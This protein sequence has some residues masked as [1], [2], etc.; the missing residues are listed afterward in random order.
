LK[1][2][3]RWTALASSA[4]MIAVP[5]G[6][7]T[8]AATS[9]AHASAPSAGPAEQTSCPDPGVLA[10][11]H[12]TQ[13]GLLQKAIADALPCAFTSTAWEPAGS[14]NL[15]VYLTPLNA[16]T[17]GVAQAIIDK[18]PIPNVTMSL[19]Q[20][21]QSYVRGKEQADAVVKQFAG[22]VTANVGADGRVELE[23][24][25]VPDASL[26]AASHVANYQAEPTIV[27]KSADVHVTAGGKQQDWSPGSAYTGS[28]LDLIGAY[29][30]GSCDQW[31]NPSTST[32]R[33][34]CSSQTLAS[35]SSYTGQSS[36]R[37]GYV[38]DTLAPSA[39][40]GPSM[41]SVGD[42]S[43]NG[44]LSL[45]RFAAG[46][47]FTDRSSGYGQDYSYL[48]DG[49][50][51][52]TTMSNV[53]D[54][55]Q[56]WTMSGWFSIPNWDGV[57]SNGKLVSCESGQV[58]NL[59]SAMPSSTI[60]PYISVG[61]FNRTAL[62]GVCTNGLAV[63]SA[64]DVGG[65]FTNVEY[66]ATAPVLLAPDQKFFLIVTYDGGYNVDIYVNGVHELLMPG[67]G[68]GQ[69][70]THS[71]VLAY[72]L[73]HL[74]DSSSGAG[75][76]FDTNFHNG[77]GIG[78]SDAHMSHVALF[79]TNLGSSA[80]NAIYAEEHKGSALCGSS[81][82][83]TDFSDQ[84][85][86]VSGAYAPWCNSPEAAGTGITIFDDSGSSFPADRIL[87]CTEGWALK[88]SSNNIWRETA[89]HCAGSGS[90]R[91]TNNDTSA[92]FW[93]TSGDNV[94]NCYWCASS[95]VAAPSGYSSGHYPADLM[96][97]DN[98]NRDSDSYAGDYYDGSSVHGV[99]YTESSPPTV[100]TVIYKYGST[101]G[102]GTGTVYAT[103]SVWSGV[104]ISSDVFNTISSSDMY[105]P[106]AEGDSGGPVWAINSSNG[107]TIAVGTNEAYDSTFQY[108]NEESRIE[109]WTGMS[110]VTCGC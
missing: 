109:S 53:T 93:A 13:V 6:V 81:G 104:S 43:I 23:T 21:V 37:I 62:C 96:L 15:V 108:F 24:D 88:D 35:S 78:D 91:G 11:S 28:G 87:N 20:G 95:K 80:V 46:G 26:T 65:V 105:P 40:S 85:G 107:K 98:T 89:G 52:G 48:G 97:T 9:A 25:K 14:N 30:M 63:Y 100:G 94:V 3:H 42:Y 56:A 31:V 45:S 72:Q 59:M 86:I 64:K 103:A 39:G 47:T 29:D 99:T 54:L 27:H 90:H 77:Y 16:H 51:A 2:F 70:D 33:S 75:I 67:T 8:L 92:P 12:P 66:G 68:T 10:G 17:R 69:S 50:N 49:G 83:S 32:N 18:N 7:S 44:D 58:C 74:G 34:D 57:D 76:S 22:K 41:T 79:S 71:E 4:V 1:P 60:D 5:F 19:K 82:T 101:S 84:A 55:S 106:L 38:G 61:Y 102:W 36:G 73:P 110:L